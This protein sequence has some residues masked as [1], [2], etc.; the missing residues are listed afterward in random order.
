MHTGLALLPRIV[1]QR[2]NVP[3][4]GPNGEGEDENEGEVEVGRGEI[5]CNCCTRLPSCANGPSLHFVCV[6]VDQLGG[7]S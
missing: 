1:V 7:P 6:C 2:A 5:R 3:A 4:T